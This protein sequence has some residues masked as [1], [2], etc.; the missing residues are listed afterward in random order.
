MKWSASLNGPFE[1][2]LDNTTCVS[3]TCPL[4]TYWRM[5]YLTS[6]GTDIDLTAILC[7]MFLFAFGFCLYWMDPMPPIFYR[8]FHLY[9]AVTFWSF[10]SSSTDLSDYVRRHLY[11]HL[12]TATE[13]F[14][15][16]QNIPSYY[17]AVEILNV[18]DRTTYYHLDANKSHC[19]PY[20][21]YYIIRSVIKWADMFKHHLKVV[22]RTSI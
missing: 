16:E 12:Y 3:H 2:N 7:I 9:R 14:L 5:I 13:K 8:R 18:L 4:V 10:W 22:V 17:P 11:Q 21:A 15:F 1:S 19:V 6:Y 20:L